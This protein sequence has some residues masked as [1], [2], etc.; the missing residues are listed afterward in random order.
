MRPVMIFCAPTMRDKRRGTA[1]SRF[2]DKARSLVHRENS[3]PAP[4]ENLGVIT[5][6]IKSHFGEDFFVLHE[7][8]STLVH[9]DMN[10]VI[11]T[12]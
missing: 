10:V 7:K 12:P 4:I 8:Q 5:N 2:K 6:Y 1:F 3:P 9:V 11:P